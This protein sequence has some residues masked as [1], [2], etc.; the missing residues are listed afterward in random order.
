MILSVF[1]QTYLLNASLR[2]R[3]AFLLLQITGTNYFY[4]P[5]GPKSLA[6]SIVTQLLTILSEVCLFFL[7]GNTDFLIDFLGILILKKNCYAGC[8]IVILI[9]SL[10]VRVK[11]FK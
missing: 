5:S 11:L 7:S 3:Y 4:Y 1:T 8:K 6:P 2:D 9:H 10:S